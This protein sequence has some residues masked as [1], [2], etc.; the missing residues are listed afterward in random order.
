[1]FKRPKILMF[2]SDPFLRNIYGKKFVK[3]GF[4]VKQ[5]VDY[6]GVIEKVI[7]E[8]P[9]IISC[10]IVVPG[11]INGFQAVELLKNNEATKDIP[12][13]ILTNM[14]Q[15]EEIEKG[16]SLGAVDYLVK[17]KVVPKEIPKKFKEYLKCQKKDSK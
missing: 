6:K 2:E 8:K 16:L 1:M 13:V 17:A 14:G 9:D 5:F 4:K 15:K 10:D 7:K 11:D 12:V 3:A